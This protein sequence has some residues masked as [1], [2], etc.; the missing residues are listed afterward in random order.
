MSTSFTEA[1]VEFLK[2]YEAETGMVHPCIAIEGES[3][4]AYMFRVHAF[5]AWLD[6]PGRV[7][8][9]EASDA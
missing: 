4:E 5:Y 6:A 8:E 7:K 2:A 9:D 1:M 3:D